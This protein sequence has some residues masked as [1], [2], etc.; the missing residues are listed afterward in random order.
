MRISPVP[1]TFHGLLFR[2]PRS[3]LD[4]TSAADA[5]IALRFAADEEAARREREGAY[6]FECL[7]CMDD[8]PVRDLPASPPPARQFS[9]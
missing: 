8:K 9:L 6:T 2:A 7:S 4:R 1:P 3:E 5:E